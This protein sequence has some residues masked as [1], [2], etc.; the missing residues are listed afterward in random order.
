MKTM[1]VGTLGDEGAE[2]HVS[3]SSS[4]NNV[5]SGDQIDSNEISNQYI[6][7]RKEATVSQ[8]GRSIDLTNTAP[9]ISKHNPRDTMRFMRHYM[10]NTS[11]TAEVFDEVGFLKSYK[12]YCENRAADKSFASNSK[13]FTIKQCLILAGSWRNNSSCK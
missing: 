11:I 1:T 2:S 5:A 8:A 6:R 7:L 4:N 12:L 9:Y 10:A 13:P 3:L